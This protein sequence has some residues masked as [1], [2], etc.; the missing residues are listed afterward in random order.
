M[1]SCLYLTNFILA[2]I[3]SVLT[4]CASNYVLVIEKEMHQ[5]TQ[6]ESAK[7]KDIK[8]PKT[9]NTWKK[10]YD[11]AERRKL[12]KLIEDRLVK[13]LGL[14]KKTNYLSIYSLIE[15]AQKQRARIK[16]GTELISK[17][18]MFKKFKKDIKKGYVYIG[19]P[20]QVLE[21]ITG[22]CRENRTQTAK[23]ISV[24]YVCRGKYGSKYYYVDQV[25]DPKM[26]MFTGNVRV[27]QD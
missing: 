1:N 24:Q 10:C 23:M 13:E 20:Y 19:M 22:Y 12:N 2:L 9:F 3:L 6:K 11:S 21:A 7:P 8:H 25:Y 15:E 5:C 18:P 4:G 14:K 26:D 16:R 27:I 17:Y